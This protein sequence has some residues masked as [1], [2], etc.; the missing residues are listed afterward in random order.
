MNTA[1]L[2]YTISVTDLR[3]RSA[4]ALE[5]ARNNNIVLVIQNSVPKAALVSLDYLKNLQ[6]VYENFIDTM[7]FN[8]HKNDPTISWEKAKKDL[9]S[10]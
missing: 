3:R 4:Y 5:E 2:P 9:L 7:S 8:R 6:G 1:T 10:E